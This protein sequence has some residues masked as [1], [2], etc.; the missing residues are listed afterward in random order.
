MRAAAL[1]AVC[2]LALTAAEI[3]T[4]PLGLDNCMQV[5]ADNPIT[6][7]RVTLGRKLFFDPILWRD[8]SI[9]CADCHDPEYSFTDKKP[10]AIE[11]GADK[12]DHRTAF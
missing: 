8:Q 1:I 3:W 9:S 4:P 5:P 10:K 6:V 12:L 7:E 11:N 2:C